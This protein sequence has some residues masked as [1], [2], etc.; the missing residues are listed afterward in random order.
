MKFS[1]LNKVI[2]AQGLGALGDRMKRAVCHQVP[3]ESM[4]KQQR[5]VFRA[6][7]KKKKFGHQQRFELGSLDPKSRVLTITP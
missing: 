4:T 7:K 2:G 1:F 5:E 3:E 6:K